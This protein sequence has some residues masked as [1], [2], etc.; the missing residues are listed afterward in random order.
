[1]IMIV[2]L[3]YQPDIAQISEQ[4]PLYPILNHAYIYEPISA[5]YDPFTTSFQPPVPSLVEIGSIH[6]MILHVKY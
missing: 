4:T 3:D 2:R 5:L 1:M 6:G